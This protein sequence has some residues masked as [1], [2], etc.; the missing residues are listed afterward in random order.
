V[1]SVNENGVEIAD[2]LSL[3]PMVVPRG[4]GSGK[5]VCFIG[6]EGLRPSSAASARTRSSHL[7]RTVSR[8]APGLCE[9]VHRLLAGGAGELEVDPV[10]LGLTR[11]EG[12]DEMDEF[13]ERE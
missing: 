5:L 1:E 4:E 2:I 10:V 9:G 12:R 6:L 7:P 13:R 8:L 3:R 11:E